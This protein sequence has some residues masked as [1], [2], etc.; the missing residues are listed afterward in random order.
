MKSKNNSPLYQSI[1]DLVRQIP[2]GSVTTYGAI[3]KQVRCSARSVGFAMAALPPGNN[4]P[5]QRV[6]NSQGRISQRSDGEGNILQHDLLSI[7]GIQFNKTGRI[8]LKNC[9]WDIANYVEA[10]EKKRDKHS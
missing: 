4:I 7:E 3:A 8:D 10:S 2:S 6:I 1:Y 9:S 5:W